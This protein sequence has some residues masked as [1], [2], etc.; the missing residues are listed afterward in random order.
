VFCTAIG[1]PLEHTN[2][3]RRCFAPLV[4]RSGLPLIRF[5]DIGHSAATNLLAAGVAVEVVARMLGHSDVSTTLRFYRHVRR[6]EL[7]VAAEVMGRL[8]GG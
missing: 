1:T 6:S 4:K 3:E 7:H 5:H 8:L 2:V